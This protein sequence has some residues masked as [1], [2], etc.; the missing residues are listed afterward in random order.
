M[1][2]WGIVYKQFTVEPS[3]LLNFYLSLKVRNWENF[4]KYRDVFFTHETSQSLQYTKERALQYPGDR[5]K[6]L[7]WFIALSTLNLFSLKVYLALL[8]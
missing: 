8:H 3:P 4:L 7:T 2:L 5:F 1:L 6:V